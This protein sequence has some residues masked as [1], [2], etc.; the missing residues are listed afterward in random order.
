MLNEPDL[1]KLLLRLMLGGLMVFH[2][3]AKLTYGIGFIEGML[4]AKGLP[5]FLA[6]G[7]YI[8]ELVAP[9]MLVIG[10]HVRVA[11]LIVVVNMLV[12]VWLVHM[13]D[14]LALTEH[15][16]YRLETQA[17]FLITALALVLLGGGKYSV[18]KS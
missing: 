2:G 5:A 14:L 12:A 6:W 8:G 17:F 13:G 4:A 9:V 16:G 10:L 18:Q 15:G 7:V 11:A 1:A 3:I